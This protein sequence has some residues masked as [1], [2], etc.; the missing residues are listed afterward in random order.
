MTPTAAVRRPAG[1]TQTPPVHRHSWAAM[2]FELVDGRPVVRETCE[3][4]GLVRRY[5]AWERYWTPG[6]PEVRR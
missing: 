3:T 4:C 2:A 5:R 1:A 6:Q